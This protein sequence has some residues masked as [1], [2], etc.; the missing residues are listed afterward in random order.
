[1]AHNT[2]QIGARLLGGAGARAPTFGIKVNVLTPIEA[3][4]DAVWSRL[5][6]PKQWDNGDEKVDF[7][8]ALAR[9]ATASASRHPVLTLAAVN[10]GNV[11]GMITAALRGLAP[12]G[13]SSIQFKV[14][15]SK[16]LGV[17]FPSTSPSFTASTQ[18]ARSSTIAS[19]AIHLVMP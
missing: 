14:G 3:D 15:H 17:S 1:M 4:V 19:S 2:L 7:S 9:P 8:H 16:S 12:P 11:A 10:E 18:A 6:M 13:A 5:Q